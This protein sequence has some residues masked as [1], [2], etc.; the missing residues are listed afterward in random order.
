MELGNSTDEI[1]V[2]LGPS[3]LKPLYATWLVSCYNHF[4]GRV[5]KLHI[6]EGW[7]KAGIS[8]LVQ[9]KTTLSPEN[10]FEDVEAILI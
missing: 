3:V 6:A 4:T 10:S 2:D 9:G 1:E 5:G 8:K 7:S